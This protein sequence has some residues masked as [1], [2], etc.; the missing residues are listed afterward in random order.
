MFL[1]LSQESLSLFNKLAKHLRAA[2]RGGGAVPS[3]REL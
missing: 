1:V 2:E 3:L